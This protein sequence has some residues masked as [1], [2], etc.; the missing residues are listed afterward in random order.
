MR[1]RPR[2]KRPVLF[3]LQ[4]QAGKQL[5]QPANVNSMQVEA[6]APQ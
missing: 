4:I 5:Q 3:S 1:E 6:V 2:G